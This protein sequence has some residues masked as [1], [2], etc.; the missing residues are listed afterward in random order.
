MRT[1]PEIAAITVH[2][3]SPS[4]AIWPLISCPR[5]PP[6][7]PCVSKSNGPVGRTPISQNSSPNS[8]VRLPWADVRLTPGA[9]LPRAYFTINLAAVADHVRERRS[10]D[11]EEDG[12][13]S[14]QPTGIGVA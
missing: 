4:C 2:I 1:M 14:E 10:Q 5:N 8:E 9:P 3:T 11:A 13:V 6:R 12:T 7:A